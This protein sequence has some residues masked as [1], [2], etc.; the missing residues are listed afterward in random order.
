MYTANGFALFL[1][2]SRSVSDHRREDG[3]FRASVRTAFALYHFFIV[4]SKTRCVGLVTIPFCHCR[5]YVS[6][7]LRQHLCV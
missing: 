3:T 7:S 5:K 2:R 6:A 4:I 1:I